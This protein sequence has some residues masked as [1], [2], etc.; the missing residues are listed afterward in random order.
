VRPN[1]VQIGHNTCFELG[2]SITRALGTDD[3]R[4]GFINACFTPAPDLDPFWETATAFDICALQFFYATL[5]SWS[6]RGEFARIATAFTM[7]LGPEAVTTTTPGNLPLPNVTVCKM[8]KFTIV[9]VDGTRDFQFFAMQAFGVINPPTNIGIFSTFPAWYATGQYIESVINAQGAHN[10]KPIFFAGHSYGAVSNDTLMARYRAGLP[11]RVIR[12]ISF[13]APK[14]GDTRLQELLASCPGISL[15]N[16]DDIV[17]SVSPNFLT[18][19]PIIV[20]FP[21][22]AL[23]NWFTWV[24]EPNRARQAVDGS[25]DFNVDPIIDTPLLTHLTTQIVLGQPFDIV[26]PHFVDE[27]R[28]RIL[29]RCPNP[30]WPI[31]TALWLY[32]QG[33]DPRPG[34]F[35]GLVAAEVPEPA[36]AMTSGAFVPA[37]GFADVE[38][39]EGAVKISG[40]V[41]ADVSALELGAEVP[42]A[43]ELG[44]VDWYVYGALGL[45]R[46]DSDFSPLALKASTIPNCNFC[47]GEPF[48]NSLRMVFSL[49]DFPVWHLHVML[50]QVSEEPGECDYFQ[51]NSIVGEGSLSLSIQ[52][53]DSVFPDMAW[54]LLFEDADGNEYTSGI[55]FTED[56]VCFPLFCTGDGELL[57]DGVTPTGKFF[58]WSGQA[59]FD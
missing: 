33:I 37:L 34:T 56:Y 26:D 46:F 13:G 52:F 16:V 47:A 32:L 18:T 43:G 29:A 6:Y 49:P 3:M 24:R 35:L 20:L 48:P 42:A 21:L 45:D 44:L 19:F 30:A 55:Q 7:L 12:S 54:L 51:F 15:A 57:L 58:A 59:E 14:P 22:L 1:P 40:Q 23:S 53:I 11:N 2:E 28:A 8:P 27:Y 17:C 39:A 50:A 10:D 4:E 31:S 36:L 41:V 38:I 9:V 25:L 5:I